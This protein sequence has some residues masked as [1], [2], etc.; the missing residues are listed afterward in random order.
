[1]NAVCG[2]AAGLSFEA[3]EVA[4]VESPEPPVD[5]VLDVITAC[6]YMYIHVRTCTY[7]YVHVLH[8]HTCTTCT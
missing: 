1:M 6:T 7:M 3:T 2:L 8:V 4:T 5:E